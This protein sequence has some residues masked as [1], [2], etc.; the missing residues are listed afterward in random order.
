[1][2]VQLVLGLGDGL[3]GLVN[4][5]LSGIG[6]GDQI[7]ELILGGGDLVVLRGQVAGRGGGRSAEREQLALGVSQLLLLG[8]QLVGDGRSPRLQIAKLD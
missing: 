6:G 5:V 1:V 4:G 3:G 8:G 2:R 7:G